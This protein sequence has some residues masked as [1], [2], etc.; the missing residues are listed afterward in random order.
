[1]NN[2]WLAKALVLIVLIAFNVMPTI[3]A[4][5][6][7]PLIKIENFWVVSPPA[8]ATNTAG[9]GVIKNEGNQA[10]TLLGIECDC[11][12][13]MLHKTEITSGKARM[14]HQSHTVIDAQSDLV[15]KP[16]SF[17]LMLMN[18]DKNVFATETEVTLRFLFEKSGVIEMKVPVR[19][20][21]Y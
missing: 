17:H 4:K 6:N 10:D 1:M 20:P 7:K 19:E 18:L 15:L 5:N 14:L 12:S 16:M 9:Y 11:A 8:V 3:Y 2:T 13:I 21:Q